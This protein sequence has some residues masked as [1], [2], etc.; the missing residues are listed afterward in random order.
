MHHERWLTFR[1]GH[2]RV[3]QLL[4]CHLERVEQAVE[5]TPQV[6]PMLC[7]RPLVHKH[8][9]RPTVL[10][11]FTDC[12]L[13]LCSLCVAPVLC[14]PLRFL[15]PKVSN[16]PKRP[17]VRQHLLVPFGRLLSVPHAASQ[18]SFQKLRDAVPRAAD[19]G[20]GDDEAPMLPQIAGITLP[21]P[22]WGRQA[23]I[24]DLALAPDAERHGP[25]PQEI[26]AA[27]L[28]TKHAQVAILH[29]E[30]LHDAVPVDPVVLQLLSCRDHD[31]LAIVRGPP[32]TFLMNAHPT[33][34]APLHSSNGGHRDHRS[35]QTCFQAHTAAANEAVGGLF[36]PGMGGP[37]PSE[38]CGPSAQMMGG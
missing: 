38:L 12:M 23:V 17:I 35:L 26:P 20:G 3:V 14:D 21:L 2:S 33:H 16:A 27:W 37:R 36:L 1:Q 29:G 25:R 8:Q 4:G 30:V 11:Q 22:G 18:D 31:P 24:V 13:Q 19:T 28:L 10:G 5:P 6:G 34:L 7:P 9:Q 15:P 32:H